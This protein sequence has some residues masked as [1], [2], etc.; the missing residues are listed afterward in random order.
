M[1]NEATRKIVRGSILY[2]IGINKLPTISDEDTIE[3][4]IDIVLLDDKSLWENECDI[5]EFSEKIN[6]DMDKIDALREMYRVHDYDNLDPYASYMY[7]VAVTTLWCSDFE[8]TDSAR[9]ELYNRLINDEAISEFIYTQSREIH[10]DEMNDAGL[11][12]PIEIVK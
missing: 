2:D 11:L 4:L 3:K 5:Q 12:S 6:V 9:S 10:L 1:N 7:N 8:Y